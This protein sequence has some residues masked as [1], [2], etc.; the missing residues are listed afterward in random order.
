MSTNLFSEVKHDMVSKLVKRFGP[1]FHKTLVMDR[2]YEELRIFCASH[3]IDEVYST[4]FLDIVEFVT[5]N[6]KQTITDLGSDGIL[7]HHLTVP[8]PE[9]PEDIA[10]NY[11]EVKVQW[12]EQLVATQR[13]KTEMIRKE[14]E[15][16][17]AV[18]DANRLKEVLEIDV[19]K[20]ILKKE[21]D[22]KLSM[23]ENEIIKERETN[24]ANVD[25]FTKEKMAEA[26]INLYTPEFVRLEMA[27]SLSQNTKFFFS[28]EDSPLGAVLSKIMHA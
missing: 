24:K 19:A 9:I 14:T 1:E 17:K 23:V 6:V 16:M 15:T 22:K 4:M 12:T 8:K 21:R 7:I 27:K 3:T 11:M 2:I 13:Q 20:A 25:A 5:K 28:G 18:S 10:K 26:N